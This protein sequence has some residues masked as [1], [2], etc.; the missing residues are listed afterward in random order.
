MKVISVNRIINFITRFYSKYSSTISLNKNLLI[1]GISGS[2][3]SLL[4]AFV[5]TK[6]STNNFT[7]SALTIIIG[8]IFAK[9][10][11]AILFHHDNKKYYTNRLTGKLNFYILKQIVKKM[12]IAD[13][14][15]DLIDTMSRFFILL[16]L[17]GNHFYPIQ[18]AI[19][20]SIISSSLSYLAINLIVKYI[21]VFGS[22][23]KKAF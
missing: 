3:I 12:I 17:L 2:I 21:N 16:E 8:F 10:I 22:T 23:T 4:V 13:S 1:S 19:I 18:A 15:F 7:T 6:L 9:A 5:S 14:V 20:S 11:F